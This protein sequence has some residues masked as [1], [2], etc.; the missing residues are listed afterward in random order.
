MSAPEPPSEVTNTMLWSE[1]KTH[2]QER[3]EQ[4]CI[5]TRLDERSIQHDK[6]ISGIEKRTAVIS[7]IGGFFAAIGVQIAGAFGITFRN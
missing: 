4:T 7:L 2:S 1:L 5:L 3:S 6:R